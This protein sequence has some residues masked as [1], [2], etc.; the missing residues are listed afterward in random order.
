MPEDIQN[1]FFSS[2]ECGNDTYVKWIVQEDDSS[3]DDDSETSIKRRLVD[4][5]L[6]ENGADPRQEG[7]FNGENV[8]IKHWW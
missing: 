7:K 8:L 6:I 3:Y 1:A 2:C 4:K 5:W